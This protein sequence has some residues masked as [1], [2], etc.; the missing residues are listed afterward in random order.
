MLA[1]TLLGTSY[2]VWLIY[3]GGQSFLL[4]SM[5]L[6]TAGLASYLRGRHERGLYAFDRKG[7]K[8]AAVLVASLGAIALNALL[9]GI[10]ALPG[11]G[12]S[13]RQVT[14]EEFVELRLLEVVAVVNPGVFAEIEHLPGG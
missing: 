7:A 3:A 1:L 4:L 10:T 8:S 9:S 6:Y 2:G 13:G 12:G 5:I 14:V 11:W